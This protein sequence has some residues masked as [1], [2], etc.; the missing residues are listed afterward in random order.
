MRRKLAI[1]TLLCTIIAT[2][3]FAAMDSLPVGHRANMGNHLEAPGEGKGKGRIGVRIQK[4]TPPYSGFAE[5]A[6]LIGL[7][8]GM[9]QLRT[10][11]RM[12]ID[13]GLAAVGVHLAGAKQ[14]IEIGQVYLIRETAPV[15]RKPAG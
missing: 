5:H 8:W 2:P 13:A 12:T 10:Q 9:Y 3:S 4:N 6:L 1:A 14:L 11:A 15:E 7:N